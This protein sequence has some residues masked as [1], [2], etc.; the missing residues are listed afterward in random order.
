M[1]Q[2]N[3]LTYGYIYIDNHLAIILCNNEEIK[4]NEIQISEYLYL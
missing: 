4:E 1:D 2:L 3:I